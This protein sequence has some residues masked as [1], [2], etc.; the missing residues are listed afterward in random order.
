MLKGSKRYETVDVFTLSGAQGP[1]LTCL[2]SP[3]GAEGGDNAFPT[4]ALL[5]LPTIC[6]AAGTGV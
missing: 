3:P 6:W 2:G 4:W 1:E 5:Q